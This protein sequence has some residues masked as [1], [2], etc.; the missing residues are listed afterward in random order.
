[1]QTAERRSYVPDHVRRPDAY[2]C[3]E[4]EEPLVV[5]GG[6]V[7][8]TAATQVPFANNFEVACSA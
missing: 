8:S 6:D 3:Y 1:M 5:G 4:L 2:T 7:A